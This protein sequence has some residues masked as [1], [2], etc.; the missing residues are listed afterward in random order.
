M[1]RINRIL[2]IERRA[3][4]SSDVENLSWFQVLP[5]SKS[6]DRPFGVGAG[7]DRDRLRQGFSYASALGQ[8]IS[9]L[10]NVVYDVCLLDAVER[11]CLRGGGHRYPSLSGAVL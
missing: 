11:S 6:D 7:E 1:E 9:H 8:E 10:S 4:I 2:R 3:D 5:N